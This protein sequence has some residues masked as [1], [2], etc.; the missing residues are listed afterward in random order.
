MQ[1]W[2][3]IRRLSTNHKSMFIVYGNFPQVSLSF[4]CIRADVAS[5]SIH[6]S[7]R[8]INVPNCL[9]DFCTKL[10][11][12]KRPHVKKPNEYLVIVEST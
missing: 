2:G 1:I 12:N 6:C 4:V 5:V 11:Y 8:P 10:E 9:K 3:M 7:M